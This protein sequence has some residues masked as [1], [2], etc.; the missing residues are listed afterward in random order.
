LIGFTHPTQTIIAYAIQAILPGFSEEG[1]LR[2][3]DRIARHCPQTLSRFEVVLFSLQETCFV[4]P[5]LT[6]PSR[7]TKK[8]KGGTGLGMSIVHNLVSKSL[9]GSITVYSQVG[10]GTRFEVLLALIA[11]VPD[12]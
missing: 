2:R 1:L 12:Q 11:P 6:E 5:L 8:G 10:V 3:A 7:V 9:H 4:C